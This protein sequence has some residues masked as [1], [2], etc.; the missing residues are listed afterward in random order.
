MRRE[1][2]QPPGVGRAIRVDS[3]D[4]RFKILDGLSSN[5]CRH[6]LIYMLGS[7]PDAAC[8]AFEEALAFISRKRAEDRRVLD[9]E[10]WRGSSL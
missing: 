4:A 10:L 6:V 9:S 3:L 1:L 8:P 2:C 7:A 5:E